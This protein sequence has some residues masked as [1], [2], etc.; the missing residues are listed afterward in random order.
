[1]GGRSSQG[2]RQFR[3]VGL[4]ADLDAIQARRAQ[5][6]EPAPAQTQAAGDQ[7]SVQAVVMSVRDEFGQILA[8]QWLSTRKEQL[9]HA[10]FAGFLNDSLP[11]KSSEFSTIWSV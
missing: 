3:L 10:Q 8:E 11:L 9:E 2:I 7:V 1:M 5:I 4:E 6:Q